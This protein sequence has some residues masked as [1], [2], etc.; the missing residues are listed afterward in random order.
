MVGLEELLRKREDLRKQGRYR[1]ADQIRIKIEQM[2]YSVTDI[3]EESK[4]A[5]PIDE[6][7]GK[8]YLALFGSGEISPTGRQI[9]EYV[10]RQI[11]KSS[12]N[13][14]IIST[15]A[16]F[17]P[18]VKVVHGEIKD[19]FEKHLTNFHPNVSIIYANNKDQA[20]DVSIIASLENSD[21]I[22]IGPGSPTYA[23]KN[24]KNTLLLSKLLEQVRRGATL[25]LAS[26][27]T[28]AFSRHT[29]PVYEI[30]KAGF[31]PYWEEGLNFYKK[32]YQ[33]ITVI[34]HFDN[35]EGGKKNDTSRVYMGKIRF[36]KLLKLLPRGEEIWG[37]DEQTAAII[38]LKTKSS[39]TQGKGRVEEIRT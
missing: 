17:Q 12:I 34:P 5:K 6:R 9:H 36:E 38:D 7:A 19:F 22:F 8:S 23:V 1:E 26:A 24:L 3:G 18:N 10:F 27:A 14:S 33:E 28:I 15:P 13:I 21:Y 35:T 30:Y 29:L 4:V 20:N 25:S 11:G 16:G 37:I 31:D 39:I 2:G 32:I